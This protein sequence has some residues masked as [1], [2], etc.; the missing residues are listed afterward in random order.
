MRKSS[1]EHVSKLHDGFKDESYSKRYVKRFFEK[2]ISQPEKDRLGSS[3]VDNNSMP[4]TPLGMDKVVDLLYDLRCDVVH[5]GKY[6]SFF[7][8]D[9]STPMVN[10]APDV[11]V[12]ITLKEFRDIVV[13]GCISAIEDKLK[14]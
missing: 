2:F 9:G 10:D 8:H 7:F 11:N 13:K 4:M 5:E 6:W 12:Y 3:F 1:I 14:P